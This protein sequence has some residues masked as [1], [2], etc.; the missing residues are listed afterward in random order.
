MLYEYLYASY[1][2]A[3]FLRYAA[4][5]VNARTLLAEDSMNDLSQRVKAS[6]I[7]V[8]HFPNDGV[9][10]RDIT[11]L[12]KDPTLFNGILE[13]LAQI[14]EEVG[15]T[16]IAGVESRGF[17]FATPLCHKLQLPCV[18]IRKP[19]KLPRAVHQIPYALEYGTDTLEL[20]QED[21][22][23]EDRVLLVDDLLATGGTAAAAA[24]LIEK[25][26]ATVAALAF[27]VELQDLVQ[28][29]LLPQRKLY[30]LAKY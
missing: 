21:C 1:Y 20:H 7:D 2:L 4:P 15:A 28:R 23:A 26:G 24:K 12:L 16:L 30:S 27:I 11:P 6:I 22:T 13:W 14:A 25:S 29:D 10:F 18:M 9:I 5:F 19:G 17:L 3:C 8:P